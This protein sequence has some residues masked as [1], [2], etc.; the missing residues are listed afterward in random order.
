MKIS[1]FI[2][3]TDLNNSLLIGYYGGTNFGDELILEV[4]MSRLSN[5]KFKEINIYY[6]NKKNYNTYH[7]NFK[8]NIIDSKNRYS[9][10]LKI[11]SSKSIIIGGGGLWG[12]DSN[13]NIFILS[14][15]MFIFKILLR[16]NIYLLGVGYY[17]SANKIGKVSAFFAGISANIIFA[18]DDETI[19]NFKKINKNTYKDNDIAFLLP[20]IELSHYNL[21]CMRISK[22][23]GLH[24]EKIIIGF[25]HFKQEDDKYTNN[26]LKLIDSSPEKKFI[27]FFFQSKEFSSSTFNKIKSI[28]K[29]YNNVSIT[30]FHFNPISLYLAIKLNSSN[31]KI[32][33]PQYHVQ[34]IA[35][36]TNTTFLPISYDN[37]NL[38]LFKQINIKKQ[39]PIN[40]IRY[41]DLKNFIDE[42]Y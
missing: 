29:K 24:D 42:K 36:L 20:E 4:L 2:N 32:V 26:I 10:F 39:I 14:F 8:Y 31:L 17:D 1:S 28:E 13:L 11:I 18:R 23:L 38:E 25:R 9:Q 30:D 3:T 37:K 5:N 27:L 34:L 41:E 33:A 6:F 22:K 40:N 16:K 12:C 35:H 19:S 15:L 21:D 7:K